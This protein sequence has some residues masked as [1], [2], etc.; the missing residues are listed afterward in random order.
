MHVS[1]HHYY[2]TYSIINFSSAL[3]KASNI[4]LGGARWV[5]GKLDVR[6]NLET[7]QINGLAGDMFS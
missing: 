3:R 2:D 4:T 1:V 7:P 6:S 5:D